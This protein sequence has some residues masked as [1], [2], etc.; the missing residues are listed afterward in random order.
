MFTLLDILDKDN[1]IGI[2]EQTIFL[3]NDHNDH[4][5]DLRITTIQE[6]DINDIN[7]ILIMI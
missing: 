5:H 4:Q 1:I 2:M 6:I 7:S 3:T